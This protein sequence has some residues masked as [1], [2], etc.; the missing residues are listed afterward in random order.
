M[1]RN[2]ETVTLEVKFLGD[3]PKAVLIVDKETGEE[4][5]LPLSQIH[6]MH[7]PKG[8][9]GEGSIVMSEWI[10]RQKGLV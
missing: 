10:A 9:I 8:G 7:R 2:E 6:E 5:W 4:L 3:S 1:S